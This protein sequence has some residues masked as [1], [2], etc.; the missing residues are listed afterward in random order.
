[1]VA[2]VRP[3]R[4]FAALEA[5]RMQAAQ[6]FAQGH[7]PATIVHR[8]QVSW[9]T[10]SRWYHTWKR[11]GRA[12][13]RAAGRAGRKPRLGA[14]AHRA[15]TAALLQGAR[16]WGFAS[17]LWTLERVVTVIA[18]KFHVPYSLAQTWRLLGQLGWSRQRPARRAQERDE[19]AIARWV[20]VRWPQRPPIRATWA[21]RGQTPQVVEP[22]NWKTLSA[23]AAVLTQPDGHRSR[24]LLAV[25]QG[26][27][28]SGQVVRFF[29]TLRGHRRRPV[30]LLWDRLPAHRSRRVAQALAGR[31]S[32]LRI[33]WLPC[34][35]PELNP[36][37][38]LWN[39]LDTTILAN[40][41]AENLARLRRSVHA[42]MQRVRRVPALTRGFLK[43]TGLFSF[44]ILTLLRKPL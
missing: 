43:Y 41:P 37:E 34:Y 15:L 23:L 36:V 11:H 22:F 16:S 6:L 28:R 9:Q 1:M 18:R 25:H 42:G 38:P 8:F 4:D 13:L 30:I 24:W 33:E 12:R 35:A 39:H 26:S 19:G 17:D 21:P 7:P 20:R 27:I 3:R 10:A 29:N 32:W 31:R 44:L 14:R 40:T 2:S 5:R